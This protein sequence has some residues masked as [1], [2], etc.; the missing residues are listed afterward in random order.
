MRTIYGTM[1]DLKAYIKANNFPK[2]SVLVLS[3]KTQKPL[4]AY[5]PDGRS[6][7]EVY[8]RKSIRTQRPPTHYYGDS[9]AAYNVLK[10][11]VLYSI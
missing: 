11:N 8:S 2:E 10:N 6:S 4:G 9:M 3:L 7:G 1:T 5:A